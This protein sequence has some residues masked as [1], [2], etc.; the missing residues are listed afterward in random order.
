MQFGPP[1]IFLTVEQNDL[2]NFWIILYSLKG[3][4]YQYGKRPEF[5][6]KKLK[7]KFKKA[8]MLEYPGLCAVEYERLVNLVIKYIFNYDQR[9]RNNKDVRLFDV[10]QALCLATK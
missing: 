10:V 1:C 2:S 7:F 4:D 9:E 3:K 5:T 8:I 6:Q